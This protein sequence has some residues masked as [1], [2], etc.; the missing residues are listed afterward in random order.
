MGG[1][2]DL[3]GVRYKYQ[4]QNGSSRFSVAS[5]LENTRIDL[6]YKIEGWDDRKSVLSR[7]RGTVQYVHIG[8]AF[9]AYGSKGYLA[10]TLPHQSPEHTWLYCTSATYRGQTARDELKTPSIPGAAETIVDTVYEGVP[11]NLAQDALMVRTSDG[12][13]W[14]VD[15]S[16]FVDGEFKRF[17][18][19]GSPKEKTRV[20]WGKGG[21][22]KW[23]GTDRVATVGYPI[24]YKNLEYV[25]TWHAVPVANIPWFSIG[26]LQGRSNE[27]RFAQ[28]TVETFVFDSPSFTGH[29]AVDGKRICDINY[30]FT[31]QPR[32]ANF[33][34]DP[35][36]G[37]RFFELVA[38]DGSG[39]KPYP[40]GNFRMLFRPEPA[41]SD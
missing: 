40:P 6:A 30:T 20:E 1:F 8:G 5:N 25:I 28:A 17:V 13:N 19:M 23:V 24:I 4:D 18:S 34:P 21:T 26:Y 33:F 22:W 36:R 31:Y 9:G 12:L 7:L 29:R 3:A 35:K 37:F 2:F 14:P 16:W 38:T 11:Y 27:S 15:E 32:G 10:R 39:T 41:L